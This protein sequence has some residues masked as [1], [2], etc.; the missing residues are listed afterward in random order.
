MNNNY[1]ENLLINNKSWA[2]EM[3]TK[4]KDYFTKLSKAQSP[5]LLWIG[6]SDSRVPANVITGTLSGEIFVHRNIANMVVSTDMNMLTVLDYAV[7]HLKVQHVVVCGHYGCGGVEA[8]MSNKS[9]GLINK[10]IRNIKEVY[11][12]NYTELNKMRDD[13]KRFDRLV[14]LNVIAQVYDLAKTSIVQ[15]SWK[16]N[17]GLELHGWVYGLENGL[18]KDLKVT[19]KGSEHLDD[20]FRLDL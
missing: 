2:E 14:E 4:D 16:D 7:N 8:A 6:C 13:K 11:R 10:W 20:I 5:P 3:I 19:M 9:L 15:K 1:Y 18:I 17:S 12:E